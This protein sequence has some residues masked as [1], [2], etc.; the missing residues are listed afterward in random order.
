VSDL[1]CRLDV[2]LWR[3]RFFKSRS[4]AAAHLTAGGVRLHRAG[5]ARR[6]EPST[7]AVPGDCLIFAAVAGPVRS[8]RILGLGRRRGPASEALTLYEEIQAALDD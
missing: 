3:A 6:A 2:W 1:R 7:Q 8:I 4:L 5:S